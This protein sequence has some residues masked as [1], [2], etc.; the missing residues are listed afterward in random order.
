MATWDLATVTVMIL[1]DPSGGP[2]P[3]AQVEVG[4]KVKMHTGT[5]THQARPVGERFIHAIPDGGE[6]DNV[7][8]LECMTQ[9]QGST[10]PLRLPTHCK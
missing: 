4:E 1:Q 2:T 9:T 7:L 8:G 3:A 10:V 5:D 6:E